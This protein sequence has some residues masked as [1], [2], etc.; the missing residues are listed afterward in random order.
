MSIETNG[1]L[2]E[3]MRKMNAMVSIEGGELTLRSYDPGGVL[4]VDYAMRPSEE[5]PTCSIDGAMVKT[6]MTEALQT[7]GVSFAELHVTETVEAAS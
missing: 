2:D 7:H 6:F 4:E 1:P 3:V 5:C